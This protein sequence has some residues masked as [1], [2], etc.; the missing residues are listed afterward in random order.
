MASRN[1]EVRQ[2]VSQLDGI[3]GLLREN[4]DALNGI[5][6]VPP[7]GDAEADERLVES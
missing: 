5:L 1:S 2:V 6:T 4:I 3:L 7:P